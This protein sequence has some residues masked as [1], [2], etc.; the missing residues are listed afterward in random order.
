MKKQRL[1]DPEDVSVINGKGKCFDSF[2]VKPEVDRESD[3]AVRST[4]YELACVL[5]NHLSGQPPATVSELVICKVQR[6]NA[7][8]M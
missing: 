4:I 7:P 5:F 8:M 2:V 6:N 1:S 3:K